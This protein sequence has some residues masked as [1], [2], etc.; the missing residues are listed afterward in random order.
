[1]PLLNDTPSKADRLKVSQRSA[2]KD[3]SLD[4]V[5]LAERDL[6]E[7]EDLSVLLKLASNTPR[8]GERGAA[9]SVGPVFR[10]PNRRKTGEES[11]LP[12]LQIPM[13]GNA[14]D[15]D[16]KTKLLQQKSSRS[17]DHGDADARLGL[18][19]DG[20]KDDK[21]KDNLDNQMKPPSSGAPPVGL[22]GGIPPGY[23]ADMPH[24]YPPMPAMPPGVPPGRTGSM[25][26]AVGVP[27]PRDGKSGSPGRPGPHGPYPHEYPGMSFPHGPHPGM[28]PPYGP[29]GGMGRYPPYGHYPPPPPR[30]MMYGAQN[31]PG[32]AAGVLQDS[33]KGK[34]KPKGGPNKRPSPLLDSKS[35]GGNKKAKKSSP[36]KKNRSPQPESPG[37]RQRSAASIQAVNAASGGKN[38][39][40]AALA[41]AILRGVTMRPSGKW[42]AQLYFAGK[43]RYIGVFDSREKAALAYEIAREKLKAGPT[44][45][46]LSAK[47]TENLVNAAR[48]AAFEGVNERA[49]KT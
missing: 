29:Y 43:S 18:S 10:S 20:S 13:I 11:D 12:G 34:A 40:A 25:R 31:P 9:P 39:K 48:K 41:A 1:M 49:P 37:D 44:E 15:K 2:S 22:Y 7:D 16:T 27:P 42:Q 3:P 30:H 33:K 45:A 24:Y 47:S 32:A 21:P 19:Q 38:D 23:R 6:M 28:Y 36:K 17:R 5:H 4:A 8:P 35:P 26:V 46:S 14:N